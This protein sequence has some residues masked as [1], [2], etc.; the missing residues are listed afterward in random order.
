ME[1]YLAGLSESQ[2]VWNFW[3]RSHISLIHWAHCKI[4]KPRPHA[5][6]VNHL[7]SSYYGSYQWLQPRREATTSEQQHTR[8]LIRNIL[9]IARSVFSLKLIEW[10]TGCKK[11]M[12]ILESFP[13]DKVLQMLQAQTIEASPTIESLDSVYTFLLVLQ[14][15]KSPL[16]YSWQTAGRTNWKLIRQRLK[17]NTA[18]ADCTGEE[19]SIVRKKTWAQPFTFSN[20]VSKCWHKS[21]SGFSVCNRLTGDEVLSDVVAFAFAFAISHK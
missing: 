19:Y 16:Q 18:S 2:G 5:L 13:D 17:A 12:L 3:T 11:T 7:V 1:T 14:R 10:K 20:F 21:L 9:D 4:E 15:F 8:H 6:L